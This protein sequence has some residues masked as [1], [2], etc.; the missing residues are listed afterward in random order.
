M[1][2]I[3]QESP[4]ETG[5]TEGQF[6]AIHGSLSSEGG[7]ATDFSQE[8]SNVVTATLPRTDAVDAVNCR[9]L[10]DCIW[11]FDHLSSLAADPLLARLVPHV[12][13]GHLMVFERLGKIVMTAE[14]EEGSQRS[15]WRWSLCP[16]DGIIHIEVDSLAILE[17]DG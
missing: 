12:V 11:T 15:G 9:S 8:K 4:C 6:L 14:V 1:L 10:P 5:F 2:V 13:L 7:E 17:V 3:F 16:P